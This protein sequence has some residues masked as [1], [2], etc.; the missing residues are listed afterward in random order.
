MSG[1][2]AELERLRREVAAWRAAY[3]KLPQRDGVEFT[4]VSGQ[5]IAPVYTSLDLENGLGSAEELPGW[6]PFTRGI[7]PTMYR[8][9][10]WTMRQFAGF[11][12]AEDTNQRYKFLLERGQ[13]GLSVAFDFPTLMGYDS[14]HPRSEGEV[15]KCGV[16]ISSL[17][18]MED[19]FA[20][21]P[22]DVVGSG[23]QRRLLPET[24]GQAVRLPLQSIDRVP[25]RAA[26]ISADELSSRVSAGPVSQG[27]GGL[28]CFRTAAI[29]AAG[30]AR[31]QRCDPGAWRNAGDQGRSSP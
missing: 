24:R 10:L 20:G 16:A 1:R 5:A 27:D 25:R 21:I 26:Q 19:L 31:G 18:D 11:G 29:S 12:T 3:G 17:K 13:T 14:D 23:H 4:S 28:L 30:N 8:G 22:L 15:G 2:D 7:H 9:R 6:W